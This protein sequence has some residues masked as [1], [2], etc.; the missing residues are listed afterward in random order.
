[1]AV[2]AISVLL[3]CCSSDGLVYAGER[4][5]TTGTVVK[6]GD[7]VATLKTANRNLVTFRTGKRNK[8]MVK[9]ISQLIPGDK[10]TV[11]WAIEE[12]QQWLTSMSGEGKLTGTV[13]GKGEKWIEIKPKEGRKQRFTPRWLPAKEGRRRGLDRKMLEIIARQKVG[14]KVVLSWMIEERKRV[15]GIEVVE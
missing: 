8:L 10:I 6:C 4:G 7:F 3:A 9:Q 12:N 2:I 14:S 11:G 13:V 1:M 15:T 5:K